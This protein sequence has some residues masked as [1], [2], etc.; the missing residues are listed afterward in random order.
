MID[1]RLCLITD[2][3]E[4]RPASPGA[5]ATSGLPTAGLNAAVAAACRAGVRLV[6]LREKDLDSRGLFELARDLRTVTSQHASRLLVND[7]VDVALAAGLDGVHCPEAGFT[8]AAARKLLGP[9]ALIGASCHSLDAVQHAADSGVDFVFFGPVYDTPSK[10]AYGPPAGLDALR[11][12]CSKAA[13]PVVAV[14]GITPERSTDCVDAG[15]SG[16]AVIS[17]ILAS[18]DITASVR[19]FEKALGTL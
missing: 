18:G 4:C 15:A 10:A 9:G 2:R 3:A 17:A 11:R 16:V 12:V 5:D 1:F 13:V 8:P 7:R 19:A 6:Q 14:G